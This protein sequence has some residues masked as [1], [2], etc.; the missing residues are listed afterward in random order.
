MTTGCDQ[1]SGT[2]NFPWTATVIW[3]VKRGMG[4]LCSKTK[5]AMKNTTDKAPN[6]LW[7]LGKSEIPR[8]CFF[9]SFLSQKKL[10]IY[11][12]TTSTTF[13]VA[14]FLDLP[15][16]APLATAPPRNVPLWPPAPKRCGRKCP[17]SPRCWAPLGST[18]NAPPRHDP[19][20]RPAQ[21]PPC[22]WSPPSATLLSQAA[23]CNKITKILRWNPKR[24]IAVCMFREALGN[25][26]AW[27]VDVSSVCLCCCVSL[28]IGWCFKSS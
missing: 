23:T 12:T 13:Q 27:Y 15:P 1:G 8:I 26:M 24:K 21:K 11:Q 25:K 5:W 14:M 7:P 17:P 10:K 16:T 28:R 9:N 18:T 19:R 4:R 22:R 6:F 3:K 2:L 20:G